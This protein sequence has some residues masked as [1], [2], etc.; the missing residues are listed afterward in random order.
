MPSDNFEVTL[1]SLIAPARSCFAIIPHNTVE[2][3][4]LP[5]AIYVGSGGSLVIRAVDS[6]Q[7]VTF[8]N[9]ASGTILDVRVS[10]VRQ[11]GTT[12]SNIIGLA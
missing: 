12:A 6:A 3:Q 10:A 4:I 7:D 11:T 1:D 2:L 5:K 9:V 8:A